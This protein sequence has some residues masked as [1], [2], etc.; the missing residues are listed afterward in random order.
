M[1][2]DRN[3][4]EVVTLLL[5]NYDS[6]GATEIKGGYSKADLAHNGWVPPN[7]IAAPPPSSL[8]TKTW[9][10]L[11]EMIDKREQFVTFIIPVTLHRNNAPYLL[12][13]FDFLWE[14]TYDIT[15][16]PGF[17]CTLERLPNT[18]TMSEAR[19]SGKLF[20]MNHFLYWQQ[21]FGIK[22]PDR[23]EL[24]NTNSWKG[25]RNLGKHLKK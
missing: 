16:A 15:T 8:I 13:E 7:I 5:V 3:P 20:L 9:P 11:G 22:T 1:W 24:G 2:L 6:L 10:T 17:S 18:T 21:V 25:T 14:N 19:E 23:R 12:N 4:N